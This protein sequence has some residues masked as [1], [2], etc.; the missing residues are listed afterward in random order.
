VKQS[1]RHCFYRLVDD[2]T[3]SLPVP[4]TKNGYKQAWWYTMKLRKNGRLDYGRIVDSSRFGIYSHTYAS[5]RDAV[6]Q[7]IYRADPWKHAKQYVEVWCESRSIAGVIEDTCSD[8]ALHLFPSG[9]FPSDS[10]VFAS[11]LEMNGLKK[12]VTVLFVGDYDD[13]GKVIGKSIN[14][15]FREHL[16]PDISFTFKR[17]AINAD[18]VRR[19]NLPTKPA[20]KTNLPSNITR[21]VEAEAMPAE[22]LCEILQHE[23]EALLPKGALDAAKKEE[24]REKQKLKILEMFAEQPLKMLERL[25]EQLRTGQIR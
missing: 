15:K 20:K 23:I 6:E 17:I 24:E 4:K 9:G 21:T 18:Q 11:A 22:I 14:A 1:V 7:I 8:Y 3:L 12:P 19:Y 25:A 5:A 10:F 13:H 16:D 2:P